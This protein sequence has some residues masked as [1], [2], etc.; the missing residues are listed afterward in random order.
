MDVPIATQV[1]ETPQLTPTHDQVRV[2]FMK[3][4]RTAW[5]NCANLSQI[6]VLYVVR[7]S[8]PRTLP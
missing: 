5:L 4:T 7:L 1:L 6:V 3:V 8:N 2:F